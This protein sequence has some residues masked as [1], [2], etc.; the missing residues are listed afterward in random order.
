M[1]VVLFTVVVI[2]VVWYRYKINMLHLQLQY[3]TITPLHIIFITA[4]NFKPIK[5][6]NNR[7]VYHLGK[8]YRVYL[9]TSI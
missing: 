3:L 1:S 9:T 4:S 6:R 2:L 7:R 8:V 5:M